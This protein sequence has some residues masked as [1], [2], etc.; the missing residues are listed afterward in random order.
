MNGRVTTPWVTFILS[1]PL[2]VLS[3]KSPRRAISHKGVGLLHGSGLGTR[4][5]FHAVSF[6]INQC[7]SKA[8]LGFVSFHFLQKHRNIENT[9]TVMHA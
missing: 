4:L 5:L 8:R 3:I 7:D 9:A 6:H 2:T 1:V